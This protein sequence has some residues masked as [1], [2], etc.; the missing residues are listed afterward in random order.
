MAFVLLMSLA[1]SPKKLCAFFV[2]FDGVD[3]P[4]FS[5]STRPRIVAE[6]I[7][8]GAQ[9]KGIGN[10]H[11]VNLK[12]AS[13]FCKKTERKSFKWFAVYLS[14]SRP[15]KNRSG[16]WSP[17]AVRRWENSLHSFCMKKIEFASYYYFYTVFE[18][19]LKCSRFAILCS[20]VSV[21]N[22]SVFSL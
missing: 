18:H 6:Q 4:W 14:Y 7:A 9:N 21:N 5:L 2:P 15:L 8:G 20:K 22:S 13:I 12:F 17:E 11:V 3:G 1:H 16:K 19:F 10:L